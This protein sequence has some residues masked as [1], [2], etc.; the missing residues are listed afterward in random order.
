[1]TLG[2]LAAAA[3]FLAAAMNTA[4]AAADHR[5][6]VLE[7]SWIK[8]GK[9]EWGAAASVSYAFASSRW[10]SPG[11]RNCASLQPF[12]EMIGKTGLSRGQ[13]Q[14][15]ARAA[16]AAWSKVTGI[17]FVATDDAAHADI[18]IG[19]QGKPSGRAFTNV[20]LDSGPVAQAAAAERGFANAAEPQSSVAE[21]LGLRQ[22]R[23]ALICFNP[24]QKWKFGF[25]GDL[26]VYDFRYTLTHEIGHAIGLDHPGMAG[27][28]MDFRYDEK[29]NGLTTGD[30]GAVQRLYGTPK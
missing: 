2:R 24:L 14:S 22:I 20:E 26:D 27:A 21:P 17:T 16:F 11:A 7:G 10:Q 8:W 13:V 3:I 15:E 1:M 18:V 30:I 28:L 9:A 12:D 6:L 5:L 29:L 19:T 23:R 4:C 25:N